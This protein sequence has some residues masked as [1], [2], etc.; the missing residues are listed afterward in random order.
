[1]ATGQRFKLI[2]EYAASVDPTI[3]P[4]Y[5]LLADASKYTWKDWAVRAYYGTAGSIAFNPTPPDMTMITKRF[6]LRPCGA[7]NGVLTYWW[8]YPVVKFLADVYGYALFIFQCPSDWIDLVSVK[9]IWSCEAVAGNMYW[10]LYGRW[11]ASGEDISTHNDLPAL[12]LTATA[13]NKLFNFQEPLNPLTLP[14]LVVNDFVAIDF[15]RHGNDAS[16]TLDSPVY[17]HG[18]EIT[19]HAYTYD[20]GV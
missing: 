9:A 19:Y 2:N 3:Q 6:I 18:I 8:I 5:Q 1:V 15:E 4:A 11:G 20:P 14:G 7:N 16:D 13:G 10:Q 12:G 17:L